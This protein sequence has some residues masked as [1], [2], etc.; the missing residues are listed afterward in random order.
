MSGRM[1]GLRFAAV[2]AVAAVGA[3][4]EAKEEG[5]DTKTDAAAPTGWQWVGEGEQQNFSTA[6]RFCRQTTVAA[7]PRLGSELK[8]QL[9]G[10]DANVRV[11]EGNRRAYW[12]CME[13]RGWKHQGR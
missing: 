9:S 2:I 10:S 13:G 7:S 8:S 11:T 4:A 5:W 1:R 3:C 12:N 6:D